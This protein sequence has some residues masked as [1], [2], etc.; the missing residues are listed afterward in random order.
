MINNEKYS[1]ISAMAVKNPTEEEELYLE[2]TD[3]GWLDEKALRLLITRRM[4]KKLSNES[5]VDR[6]PNG[7]TWTFYPDGTKK[8]IRDAQGNPVK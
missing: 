4:K 1:D 5:Y 2:L 6:L 7:E 3:H 8:M